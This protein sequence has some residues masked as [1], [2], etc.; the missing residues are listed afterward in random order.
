LTFAKKNE[1]L[2]GKVK[3]VQN[4]TDLLYVLEGNACCSAYGNE[5]LP[6]KKMYFMNSNRAVDEF[7]FY[8]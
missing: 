8:I 2:D 1:K 3:F 7:V 6:S 5:I 4:G